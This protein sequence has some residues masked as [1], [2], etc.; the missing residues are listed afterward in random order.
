MRNLCPTEALAL[1]FVLGAGLGS[2]IHFCFMVLLLTVRRFRC[3]GM[4]REERRARRHARREERRLR[5]EE[6]RAAREG[7]LRL[8]GEDSIVRDDK[9]QGEVL[10]PYEEGEA[11][12]LVPDKA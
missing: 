8:E 11:V 10:P 9:A 2:I 3:R 12:T 7:R 6:R 1:A 4:T 5:K